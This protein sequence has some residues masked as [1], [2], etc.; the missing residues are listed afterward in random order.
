MIPDMPPRMSEGTEAL[1]RKCKHTVDALLQR[2]PDGGEREPDWPTRKLSCK[3]VLSTWES[4]APWDPGGQAGERINKSKGPVETKK[5]DM[6]GIEAHNKASK[7]WPHQNQSEGGT[8]HEGTA[9]HLLHVHHCPN[10]SS[11]ALDVKKPIPF[12]LEVH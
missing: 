3:D 10:P 1:P 4:V 5:N 9:T 11:W 2:G 12:C 6:T 8:I 7:T